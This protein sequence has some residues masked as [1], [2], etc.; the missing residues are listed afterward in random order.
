[1]QSYSIC[2]SEDPKCADSVS[3]TSLNTDDHS[4]ENYLKLKVG[5]SKDEFFSPNLKV[6]FDHKTFKI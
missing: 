5:M 4:L 6:N 1:M 2:K 3:A